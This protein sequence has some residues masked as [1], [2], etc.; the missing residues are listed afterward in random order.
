MG[1]MALRDG[2]VL[3]GRGN[4]VH[5]AAWLAGEPDPSG[6]ELFGAGV[7]EFGLEIFEVAE[8]FGDDLGDGAVGIA[9]AFGLHDFPEHGVVDVAAAVVADCGANVF[10]DGVESRISSS[11]VF[12]DSSGCF[13]MAA[14]RFLT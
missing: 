8:G 14:L 9:A 11:A 2:V 7:V 1:K 5:V 10:G 12:L 4:D 3:I 13:S 6:A